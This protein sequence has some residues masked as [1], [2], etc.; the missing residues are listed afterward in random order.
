VNVG[1]KVTVKEKNAKKTQE[2][3]IV[4][5]A[6]ADPFE[7][8]ISNESPLGRA[9]MGRARGDMVEVIIPDGTMYV[10]IM[11]IKKQEEAKGEKK[12]KAAASASEK[13]SKAAKTPKAT[14]KKQK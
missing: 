14:T 5:S 4:G 12:G 7:G 11:D 10:K 3:I 1:L 8:K 2:Y 9:L 13:T 6:E